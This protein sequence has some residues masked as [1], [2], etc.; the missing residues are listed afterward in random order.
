MY[1][2][3]ELGK[4][5]TADKD[6]R[7]YSTKLKFLRQTVVPSGI[8]N[9]AYTASRD[10]DPRLICAIGDGS[11]CEVNHSYTLICNQDYLF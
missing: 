4:N 10:D 9:A 8:C 11:P 1:N 2:C 5:G 3:L 7:K 6:T